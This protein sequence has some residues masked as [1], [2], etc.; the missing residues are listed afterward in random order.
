MMQLLV[1]PVK[2][3]TVWQTTAQ[4]ELRDLDVWRAFL[5]HELLDQK[6]SRGSAAK[7]KV[8]LNLMADDRSSTDHGHPILSSGQSQ[9]DFAGVLPAMMR[10]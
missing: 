9:T 3:V 6:G 2:R 5:H 10:S 8:S 1:G 4:V 7:V